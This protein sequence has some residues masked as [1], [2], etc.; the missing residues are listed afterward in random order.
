LG[1]V[2]LGQ[3]GSTLSGGESQRLKLST[4][5]H[6]GV[7]NTP[8]LFIFDEPTTGLHFHDI[9]KL[10]DAFRLLIEY[11]H[12]VMVIEHNMEILKSADWIIDLGPEGGKH[13]GNIVGEGTPES[14]IDN[15]HSYTA[16]YIKD[17]LQ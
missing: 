16:Q 5:L 8:V 1:Y 7:S 4:Y 9:N 14:L 6:K 17:K 15:K 3:S 10:L 13:G 12:T 2:K 11:G